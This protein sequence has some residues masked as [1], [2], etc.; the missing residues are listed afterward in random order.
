[1]IV[2]PA[3]SKV[4]YLE[5]AQVSGRTLTFVNRFTY[6]GHTLHQ[7]MIDDANIRKQTIKFTIA[8]NT[9]ARTIFSL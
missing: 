7:D 1:M 4:K 6:L 2:P 3:R 8:D 5:S 9:L